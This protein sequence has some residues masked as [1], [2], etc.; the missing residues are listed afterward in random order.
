MTSVSNGIKKMA[1]SKTSIK[2]YAKKRV[3]RLNNC[4]YLKNSRK[5]IGFFDLHYAKKCTR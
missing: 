5:S 2:M 4:Y 1:K 3:G